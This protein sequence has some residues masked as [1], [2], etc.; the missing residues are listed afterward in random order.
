[1]DRNG[2]SAGAAL[3]RTHCQKCH[4]PPLQEI[5]ADLDRLAYDKDHQPKYWWQNNRGNWYIKV[6]DV[7]IDYVGTDPR[8][9]TDF[10]DRTANTGDLGKGVV[11]ASIGLDLVT[12]GIANRFFRE[13]NISAVDQVAWAGGR[14]PSDLRIRSE[15]IYKARPLNG[16]WAVAPYLHNGSV[17]TLE[18]LLSPDDAA[19]PKTFWVGS[20][21]FD[22]VTV[23][24]DYARIKGATLFDTTQPGNA[25]SGHRFKNGPPG[26]GVIGRALFAAERAQIIEFLKSQ[27]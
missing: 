8:Q 27:D 10:K 18:A 9:A 4:L 21:Q 20:K 2:E 23:G 5:M 15:L 17:P 11:S 25:N 14:D 22:P 26:N 6:T 3:Y 12:R 13:E 16:I 19:R 24:Y 7:D 1:M